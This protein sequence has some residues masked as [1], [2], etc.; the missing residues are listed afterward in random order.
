MKLRLYR[1]ERKGKKYVAYRVLEFVV[2]L[3]AALVLVL[4]LGQA[5]FV[6]PATRGITRS[7]EIHGWK[8]EEVNL[9][10]DGHTTCLWYLPV[11]N[12]RGVV[13]FSHGNG[14]NLDLWMEAVGIY[15][16]LGFSVLLYDYGGYGKSTGRPSEKRC[17]NDARAV[18]RWLTETKGVPPER[19]VLLGRSLGSGVAAQLATEVKPGAVI[20]E[21]AFLSVGHIARRAFPFMPTGLLLRHRFDTQSKIERIGAPLL[22]VH[23][24]DDSLVPYEHGQRLFEKATA[25]KQFLT[26][27][28]GGH[29]EAFFYCEEAYR[30]GLRAFLDPLFA[31]GAGVGR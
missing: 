24:R 23:S 15:R 14:G 27:D 25:P 10:V 9:P 8:F 28:F 5:Y 31:P 17:Y 20:L 12:A 29:D 22:F 7:P 16:D 18:W 30:E 13:L 6:F 3:Y 11:E 26:L 21:S 19:V 4:T 1:G 2:V